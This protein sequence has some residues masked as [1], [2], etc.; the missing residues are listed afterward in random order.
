M[1]SI[2]KLLNMNEHLEVWRLQ[3]GELALSFK[4]AEV[5]NGDFLIGEFGVGNTIYEA[6]DSYIEKI[7]GKRLVFNAA[8][9]ARYEVLVI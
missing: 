1:D 4:N 7:S 3:T 8:T 5:K 9:K 2:T 6:A